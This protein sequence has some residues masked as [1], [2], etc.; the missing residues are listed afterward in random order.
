MIGIMDNFK[1]VTFDPKAHATEQRKTSAGLREAYDALDDEFAALGVLLQA[2]KDAG[3]TEA[4]V[5]AS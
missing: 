1:P 3:M 5:A 4:E 2:R